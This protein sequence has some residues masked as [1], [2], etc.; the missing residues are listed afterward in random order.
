MLL[1]ERA[2][3]GKFFAA[4]A[5]DL[6]AT[7]F[8]VSF[9]RVSLRISRKGLNVQRNGIDEFAGFDELQAI[10]SVL[11]VELF[12]SASHTSSENCLFP[13]RLRM[14]EA[15]LTLEVPLKAYSGL[16]NILLGLKELDART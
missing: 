4:D 12:S 2:G 3:V 11:T 5:T 1:L 13:M 14:K 6:Q 15:L 9:E 10:D 8:T 16:M 7:I